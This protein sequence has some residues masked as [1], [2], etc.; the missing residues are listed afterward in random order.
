MSDYKDVTLYFA[1]DKW[2]FAEQRNEKTNRRRIV[3]MQK[4]GNYYW[5]DRM[6]SYKLADINRGWDWAFDYLKGRI[7]EKHNEAEYYRRNIDRLNSEAADLRVLMG[8]L[9]KAR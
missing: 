9:E 4:V 5:A 3:L 6:A 8:N 1:S 2:R 7:D